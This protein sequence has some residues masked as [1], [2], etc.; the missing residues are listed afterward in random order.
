MKVPTENDHDVVTG[1]LAGKMC[2]T[3]ESQVTSNGPANKPKT[4]KYGCTILDEIDALTLTTK[5]DFSTFL[6]F[7]ICYILVNVVY[8]V[9][10]TYN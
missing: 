5:I 1:K 8:W 4:Q 2:T 7:N 10:C 3:K 9:K 6:L